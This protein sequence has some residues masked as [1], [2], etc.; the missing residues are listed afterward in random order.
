[1]AIVGLAKYTHA[2]ARNFE[3]TPSCRRITYCRSTYA[4]ITYCRSTYPRITYRKS[5][6]PGSH[7]G[8]A[9][10]PGSHTTEAHTQGLHTAEAHTPGSHTE[11]AHTPESHTAGARTP[12][13]H[14]AE[15]HTPRLRVVSNFGDGDCGAGEI[16]TRA[17]AKIRGDATRRGRLEISRARVCVFRQPHNRSQEVLDYSHNRHRQY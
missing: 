3:A 6:T 8:E 13:S 1:M 16:H 14:T 5:H 11:E 2:R 4:W 10:T 17:R 9:H 7:I 15:A 12:E